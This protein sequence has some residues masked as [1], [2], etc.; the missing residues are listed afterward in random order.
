[1][2]VRPL[3]TDADHAKAVA[4][5]ETLMDATP[6]SEAFDRL[7]AL[8]KS[9]D[10]YEAKAHPI[11]A[12]DPVDAILF[13]LEQSGD[14][15]IVTADYIDVSSRL[16]ELGW[17]QPRDERIGILPQR[18]EALTPADRRMTMLSRTRAIQK[19]F[20]VK[21]VPFSVVKGRGENVGIVHTASVDWFTGVGP[22]LFVAAALLRENPHI[23]SLAL[24]TLANYLNALFSEKGG[25][26][27]NATV[28]IVVE[29][30]EED[31]A[32]TC[33]KIT[34]PASPEVLTKLSETFHKVLD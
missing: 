33:K 30:Y 25:R 11:V 28:E 6:G 34:C 14:P 1:M 31:G 8:S 17:P 3:K 29:K 10:A 5:I 20:K 2:N 16:E 21:K 23:L 32:R 26:A 22:A 7:E 13:H 18:F 4:E 24:E 9:V 27:G 19:L 15:R 12:P